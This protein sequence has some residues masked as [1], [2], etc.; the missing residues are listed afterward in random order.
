MA[1]F[2]SYNRFSSVGDE[3]IGLLQ[4]NGEPAVAANAPSDESAEPGDR[5]AD[6]QVLHL[7]GAL[8]GVEGLGIGE[9]ARDV[10]VGDNA[11]TAQ[12]L[13]APCNGLARLGRA[14]RLGERRVM[15]AELSVI[16]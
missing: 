15:V 14:V 7:V 5:L 6:D 4:R 13:A 1:A 8:V 3:L 2:F 12:Q 11:V 10:V 16:I 9:K